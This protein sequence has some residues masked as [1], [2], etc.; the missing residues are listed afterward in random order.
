MG[1]WKVLNTDRYPARIRSKARQGVRSIRF[2]DDNP[3]RKGK[4]GRIAASIA[5]FDS[6]N[7][8]RY[9]QIQISENKKAIKLVPKT[10]PV[11]NTRLVRYKNGEVFIGGGYQLRAAGYRYGKYVEKDEPNVFE[12]L[13]PNNKET[14]GGK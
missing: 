13:P 8:A 1:K 6:V 5:W 14:N 4:S 10:K 9:V 2:Y 11:A 12:F 7:E 3:D